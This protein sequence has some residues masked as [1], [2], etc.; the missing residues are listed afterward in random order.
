M[1]VKVCRRV[2]VE[3]PSSATSGGQSGG[4]V[5]TKLDVEVVGEA[6]ELED[7]EVW[8]LVRAAQEAKEVQVR[9]LSR[10]LCQ[11]NWPIDVR[12]KGNATVFR[13]CPAQ[14]LWVAFWAACRMMVMTERIE[15]W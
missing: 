6:A 1:A 14:C 9:Q 2:Q 12:G 11:Q 5:E 10:G 15:G 13:P 8:D 4:G 7:V 3:R